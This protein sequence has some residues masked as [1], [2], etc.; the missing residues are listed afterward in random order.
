M[1]PWL[2]SGEGAILHIFDRLGHDLV[3]EMPPNH[4]QR[5]VNPGG[6]PAAR[7]ELAIVDDALR[8]L[9]LDAWEFLLHPVVEA[10]VIGCFESVEKA[11]MGRNEIAGAD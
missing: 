9:H 4:V 8:P 10:V 1:V 2:R 5:G 3:V 6:D 11:G 7:D